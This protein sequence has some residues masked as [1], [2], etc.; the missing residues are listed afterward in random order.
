MAKVTVGKNKNHL[1]K[2]D[3]IVPGTLFRHKNAEGVRL[4]T[5][6]GCVYLSSGNYYSDTGST[7]IWDPEFVILTEEVTLVN[8]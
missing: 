6:K 5:S 4:K 3:T 8:E 7:P 1:V 2:Y